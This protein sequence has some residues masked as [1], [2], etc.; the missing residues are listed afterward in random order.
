M[1]RIISLFSDN[2]Q[3]MH[4]VYIY[5]PKSSKHR[6]AND[7]N[8]CFGPCLLIFLVYATDVFNEYTSGSVLQYRKGKSEDAFVT[9]VFL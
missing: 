1:K 5:L 4:T 7:V 9:I 2:T 8:Q 3:T 6:L